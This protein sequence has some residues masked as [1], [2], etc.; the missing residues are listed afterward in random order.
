MAAL[1]MAITMVMAV[2]V[3]DDEERAAD[4]ISRTA[5]ASEGKI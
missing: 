3:G 4:E 5:H 2:A 1:A